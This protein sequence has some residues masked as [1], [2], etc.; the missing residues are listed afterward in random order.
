M[1]EYQISD[2]FFARETLYGDTLDKW[3][4]SL[5][6]VEDKSARYLAER[7]MSKEELVRRRVKRFYTARQD[8]RK[9]FPNGL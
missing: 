7:A 9:E 2:I 6:E 4:T 5:Q 8:F 3:P 1:S